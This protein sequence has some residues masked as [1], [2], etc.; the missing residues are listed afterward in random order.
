MPRPKRKTYRNLSVAPGPERKQQQT[1]Q[2][3]LTL[4]MPAGQVIKIERLENSGERREMSDEEFTALAGDSADADLQ[5]VLEEAYAAGIAD[6]IQDELDREQDE[7]DDDAE[8]FRRLIVRRA[9]G[10]KL[11]RQGIRQFVLRRV[12]QRNLA[13]R[14]AKQPAQRPS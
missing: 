6:A 7:E 4:G 11:L 2:F 13:E 1:Q 9:A 3:I 5:P 8:M 12:I 14:Q 10:R